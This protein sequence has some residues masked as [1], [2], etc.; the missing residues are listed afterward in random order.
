MV[1]GAYVEK[2]REVYPGLALDHL[3]LISDGMVNDVVVV[4][5]EL[6]CRFVRDAGDAETLAREAAVLSVIH[7]R[8]ELSTPRLERLEAGFASYRYIPGEPLS[9]NALA[10]LSAP[11]RSR[12]IAELGLFHAQ[13]HSIPAA[14]LTASGVPRSASV[15]SRADWLDLYDRV[16]NTLFPHLWTHQQVWVDELF[17]PL[18]SG[19]LDLSYTPTLV[20]GDLANYH[21]LHDPE[22]ESLTGVIDFGVAGLGD[23]ACDIAVQLGNY[24]DGVVQRMAA[25]YPR[26]LDV[27]DR[28]RFWAGTF[29][30][31]WGTAGLEHKDVSLLLAHIGGNRET[32]SVGS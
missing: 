14:A 18:V 25:D 32:R 8:V 1:S 3:Q 31:Q 15:R 20:H 22:R 7:D 4:N 5:R 16:R 2:I 12:I 29:E 21:I 10:R 13:L 19:Q 24:G 23:P 30:L 9:R 27:I 17:A 26:L 11:G 6:V 28:A